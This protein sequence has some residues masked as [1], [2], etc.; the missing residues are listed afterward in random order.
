MPATPKSQQGINVA[1]TSSQTP[2]P[3]A[4]PWIVSLTTPEGGRIADVSTGQLRSVVTRLA[5]ASHQVW[6]CLLM[7]Q[8]QGFGVNTIIDVFFSGG[9]NTPGH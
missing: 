5:L 2:V 9:L 4:R 1:N 6:H 8:Q 3:R 7:D